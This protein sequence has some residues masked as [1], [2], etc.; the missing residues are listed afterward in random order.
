MPGFAQAGIWR[1]FSTIV[2]TVTCVIFSAELFFFNRAFPGIRPQEK[3]QF[4][5][6]PT[7]AS[8]PPPGDQGGAN[9]NDLLTALEHE[10]GHILG[11][12]HTDYGLMSPTPATGIRETPTAVIDQFFAGV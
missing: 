8:S 3:L 10:L 4:L 12:D 2:A 5:A 6:W 7:T 11:Y 1:I 9:H